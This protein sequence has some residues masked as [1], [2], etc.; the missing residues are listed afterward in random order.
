M[1]SNAQLIARVT[2]HSLCSTRHVASCSHHPTHRRQTFV[3]VLHLG[4][5]LLR[6]VERKYLYA[7]LTGVHFVELM[8]RG[9]LQKKKKKH[10]NEVRNFSE[11]E[12]KHFGAKKG[13]TFIGIVRMLLS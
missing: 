9:L 6:K 11:E 1:V 12:E 4:P 3:V 2:L 5:Y 7:R 10:C 13:R 8:E